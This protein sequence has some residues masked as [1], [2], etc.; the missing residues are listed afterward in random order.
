MSYV[1]NVWEQ[2]EGAPWAGNTQEADRH[3]TALFDAG[4]RHNAKFAELAKRLARRF[5]QV[6]DP[7][8]DGDIL[9]GG[10]PDDD[11]VWNIGISTS[12]ER[13][14]EAQVC[15]VAEA[16]A[17][18]L[19]V[20]DGQA[21]EVHLANGAVF[22]VGG[23][24]GHC[25]K[26]IAALYDGR[27]DEAM[28]EL[29]PL[30]AKGNPLAR[31]IMGRMYVDGNGVRSNTVVGCALVSL[32]SGWMGAGDGPAARPASDSDAEEGLA[33]RKKFPSSVAAADALLVRLATPGRLLDTIDGYVRDVEA[34]YAHAVDA[35][36]DGRHAEAFALAKPLAEQ[37][38]ELAQF[39]LSLLHG[40]GLGVTKDAERAAY[41]TRR[42][43]QGGHPMAQ[44]N[45]ALLYQHGEVFPKDLARAESWFRRAAAAG[46]NRSI[47]SLKGLKQARRHDTLAS[48]PDA[49]MQ[50]AREGDAQAQFDIG[51]LHF[52]GK[53]GGPR[54]PAEAARFYAQAAA[55]GH[56]DA[57]YALGCL[58]KS[59]DGMPQD[60][61][62][63]AQWFLR[64]A[65]AGS[66][67][68]QFNIGLAYHL[69]DGVAKDGVKA[70]QWT[71]RAAE[72]FH[73]DALHNLGLIYRNGWA[74]EADPVAANAL[75]TLAKKHGSSQKIDF[76]FAPGE[77]VWVNQLVQRMVTER[78]VL[79]PLALWRKNK[80]APDGFVAATKAASA[81]VARA[82]R[83]ETTPQE[84]EAI[85]SP[86]GWHSGHAA[87]VVLVACIPVLF[88]LH[89]TPRTSIVAM[90]LANL[91]GI[92]G[93][94]RVGRNLG[95]AGARITAFTV[96]TLFPIVGACIGILL[97]WQ[98]RKRR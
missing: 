43:A 9:V 81:G 55:Q 73:A 64:A 42:A 4:P 56:A 31:Q 36:R 20:T 62:E 33:L 10:G 11:P 78:K 2:P 30:A 3:L 84:E 68:A 27:H 24:R 70:W 17:L 92:Y 79:E 80:S 47:E 16:N 53:A 1:V 59:G 41:W 18:G 35:G 66:T 69:G 34:R 85:A 76:V 26:A 87:L 90:W 32:G 13:F 38:H 67:E 8:G 37:G 19:N 63:A 97:L 39:M 98:T 15:I 61:A 23:S 49:A 75:F 95:Y 72:S 93:V 82:P 54:D 52:N 94:I 83:E 50:R 48:S 91:I 21:G 77:A 14:E 57:M 58:H 71:G 60:N 74:V 46:N 45:L 86:A 88:V 40:D 22:V 5:P 96:L 29:R 44:H 89:L 28:R 51:D 7:D 65:E 12:S 25:V 6:D